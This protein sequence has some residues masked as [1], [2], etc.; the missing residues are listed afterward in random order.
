MDFLCG[1]C[2]WCSTEFGEVGLSACVWSVWCWSS[3]AREAEW[4]GSSIFLD[5]PKSKGTKECTLGQVTIVWIPP[6]ALSWCFSE[7]LRSPALKSVFGGHSGLSTLCGRRCKEGQAWCQREC[8]GSRI[9]PPLMSAVHWDRRR[10][11]SGSVCG[12]TTSREPPLVVNFF[13]Y[14]EGQFRLNLYDMEE[15][16]FHAIMLHRKMARPGPM[17][18]AQTN[19]QCR[20]IN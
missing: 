13:F 3:G 19:K 15:S 14:V 8:P 9:Y 2:W 10:S 4:G 7:S 5:S 12:R 6:P 1:K 11:S 20:T 18:R 16:V 17:P